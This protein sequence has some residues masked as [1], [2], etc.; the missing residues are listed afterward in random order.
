[1]LPSPSILQICFL[2]LLLSVLAISV[3]TRKLTTT[4]AVIAALI[5][6]LLFAATG[7]KGTTILLSFFILSVLATAH[8]KMFKAR[9]NPRGVHAQ[10][11]DSRQ[12]LANG[13]VAGLLSF[14]ILLCPL[15]TE[16]L[17]VMM[18]AS[19]AS[20]FADTLSSELGMVYGRR[21][22]HILSFKRGPNGLDGVVSIEGTLVG[23]AG[24]VLI[25]MLYAGFQ[26]T[27]LYITFAG[28]VGNFVDSLLGA[29]LERKHL[30][31]NNMV[32]FLNTLFAAIVGGLLY[33]FF[34]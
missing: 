10:G 26:L 13:G 24:A 12:V 3:F 29:T 2:T 27:A 28:I 7:L 5:A 33:W 32:N 4:A 19:L 6:S 31:G 21:F 22:Y 1:M 15:H 25:A 34:N 11:R 30:I 20:A 14:C 17:Q 16:V 18:A 9:L 23:A 8:K